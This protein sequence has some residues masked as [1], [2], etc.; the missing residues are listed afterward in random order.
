MTSSYGRSTDDRQNIDIVSM[1]QSATKHG[2]FQLH[3][4]PGSRPDSADRGQRAAAHD[5]AGRQRRTKPRDQVGGGAHPCQRAILVSDAAAIDG[6]KRAQS[7][8]IPMAGD[9]VQ[10]PKLATDRFAAKLLGKRD[11]DGLG[12]SIGVI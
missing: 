4:E 8:L 10:Q 2:V 9:V 5:G 1:S 7:Y 6:G 11:A 12:L 3:L